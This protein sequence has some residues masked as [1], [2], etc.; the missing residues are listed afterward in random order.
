[1]NEMVERL[2]RRMCMVVGCDPDALIEAGASL[3][4]TGKGFTA[5]PDGKAHRQWEFW[6]HE[7]RAAIDEALT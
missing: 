7:A 6:V 2:A 1:M 4:K 3:Q 5:I